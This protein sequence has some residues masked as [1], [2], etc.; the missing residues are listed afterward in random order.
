[1]IAVFHC[2]LY[3]FALGFALFD[4]LEF[5]SQSSLELLGFGVDLCKESTQVLQEL[6]ILSVITIVQ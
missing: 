2:L 1:M 6:G 3:L 4:D 5:F